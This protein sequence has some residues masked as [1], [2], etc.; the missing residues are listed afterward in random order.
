MRND[1]NGFI[2]DVNIF[3]IMFLPKI[4]KILFKIIL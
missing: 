2:P 4:F 1:I 3:R